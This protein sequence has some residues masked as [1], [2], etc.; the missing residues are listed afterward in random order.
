MHTRSQGGL[1]IDQFDPVD[2]SQKFDAAARLGELAA[3]SP[4]TLERTAATLEWEHTQTNPLFSPGTPLPQQLQTPALARDHAPIAAV[5]TTEQWDL[6][7][8]MRLQGE[9][10]SAMLFD[11]TDKM[12]VNT[13]HVMA[14]REVD[15]LKTAAQSHPTKK[16]TPHPAD[17]LNVYQGHIAPATP[18]EE[19]FAEIRAA[20]NDRMVAA[21]VG[22]FSPATPTAVE[23]MACLG[24]H[25]HKLQYVDSA[26]ARLRAKFGALEA[27][28]H[29]RNLLYSGEPDVAVAAGTGSSAEGVKIERASSAPATPAEGGKAT[30]ST[31]AAATSSGTPAPA[32]KDETPFLTVGGDRIS[33]N[34][35][36]YLYA[37]ELFRIRYSPA[38]QDKE[39]ELKTLQQGNMSAEQYMVKLKQLAAGLA[40]TGKYTDT[41]VAYLFLQGLNDKQCSSKVLG[42]LQS[43]TGVVA[44]TH[45]VLQRVLNY[46]EVAQHILQVQMEAAVASRM[47]GGTAKLPELGGFSFSHA[48]SS[49][50]SGG[51]SSAGNET[52]TV[53]KKRLMTLALNK[54]GPDHAD[55]PCKL[56]HKGHSN[57]EC[58]Q[59]QQQQRAAAQQAAHNSSSGG[60]NNS[61]QQAPPQ[62]AAAA[63]HAAAAAAP[64]PA[65]SNRSPALQQHFNR[66]NN[67]QQQQQQRPA[68]P[69]GPQQQQNSNQQTPCGVC[70]F[71]S[72]HGGGACYYDRPDAAPANWRPSPTATWAAISHY[73]KRCAELGVQPQEPHSSAG[74]APARQQGGGAART[75]GAL[76][77]DPASYAPEPD[78]NTGEEGDWLVTGG[79]T[80][81]GDLA[82]AAAASNPLGVHMEPAAAVTRSKQPHSYLP[83][84]NTRPRAKAVNSS[85][86]HSNGAD[87]SLTVHLTAADLQDAETCQRLISLLGL[88]K[89]ASIAVNQLAAAGTSIAGEQTNNNST[90]GEAGSTS[91]ARALAA[92]ADL[93]AGSAPWQPSFDEEETHNA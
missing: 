9:A 68:K 66:W 38:S 52:I 48:S 34:W 51:V 49:S 25:A 23:L 84:D 77:Q 61:G 42:D 8:M 74:P 16:V 87:V 28:A 17:L 46:R 41:H 35:A 33:P 3:F 19:A 18:A 69:N 36:A 72:G 79:M 2:L 22:K 90:S 47:L 6:A 85:G 10:A 14:H 54:H 53:L 70:G 20:I 92:A 50:S 88:K 15:K 30:S 43:Q 56:G 31:A 32:Q 93:S 1:D 5:D 39:N 86:T 83:A 71:R 57:A 75:A 11:G 89:S 60:Y 40:H 80:L 12:D 55:A 24:P 62:Y 78:T 67:N 44:S 63:Y 73:N 91:S 4:T 7:T 29:A 64:Q 26:I 58:K 82:A 45:D 65:A 81:A 37:V 21:E 27:S 59:Q 13:F 76:L